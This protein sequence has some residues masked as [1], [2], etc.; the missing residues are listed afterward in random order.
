LGVYHQL[1]LNDEQPERLDL[2]LIRHCRKSWVR[3]VNCVAAHSTSE[4]TGLIIIVS[5][6][7]YSEYSKE[8]NRRLLAGLV[9]IGTS[10][11]FLAVVTNCIVR[12]VTIF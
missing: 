1:F 9:L 6:S 3:R 4:R 12:Y 8:R 5:I 10:Y 2:L 7:L 11:F